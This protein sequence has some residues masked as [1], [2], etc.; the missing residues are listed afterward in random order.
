MNAIFTLFFLL[1]TLSLLFINPELFLPTV[2]DATSDAAA[3]C[4]ALLASYAVWMGLMQVWEECGIIQKISRVLRPICRRMFKTD[5]EQTLQ[6]ISANIS[7]NL[8]GLGSAATPYGIKAARLL[9]ESSQSEYS[10]CMLF[11]LNATSLQIL[12]TSVVGLRAALGS[13]APADI[14]VPTILCSAA[15]TIIACLLV[16][17]FLYPASLRRAKHKENVGFSLHLTTKTGAGTR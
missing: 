9:N 7:C 16:R 17:A 10:S 15:S 13:G 12:P 8:L 11:V 3:L 1:S 14:I 6:A 4:V 5:N 2:L